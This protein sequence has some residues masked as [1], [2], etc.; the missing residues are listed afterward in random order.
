[1]AGRVSISNLRPKELKIE[2]IKANN[3]DKHDWWKEKK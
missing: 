3:Q 2:N 1:M